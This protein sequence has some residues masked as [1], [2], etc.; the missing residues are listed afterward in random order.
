MMKGIF[1]K[2]CP[3]ILAISIATAFAGCAAKPQNLMADIEPAKVTEAEDVAAGNIA[4]TDFAVR[5]FAAS[6]EQGKNA[7]ISPLSVFS[8]LAMTAN[9]AREETLAQMEEVLGMSL[10]EMNVY[11]HTY[12]SRLAEG[13]NYKLSL[14]NSIWALDS[15][16][17]I[18]KK[19][20]LQTTADY[21][22][23]EIYQCKFDDG[24]L[25][26][27][28]RWVEEKTDGMIP[29]ILKQIP[30]GAVM[31]LVN[32]LAFDA[33]WAK[34]YQKS[35]VRDGIF[36]LEDGIKRNVE[37]MYSRESWYLEDDYA[38]GLIKY[39][40]DKAYAFVAL[41]PKEGVSVAQYIDTL[42][43]EHLNEL[44]TAPLPTQVQ[45]AIPKFESEYSLTMNDI[46]IEMGMQDAFDA[47]KAD[48]SGRYCR[49]SSCD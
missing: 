17:F 8:A 4:A 26:A 24:T 20:F 43:G 33:K 1:T 22:D 47:V 45:A 18:P 49:G 44:L 25:K 28:N 46:L 36:T 9:G 13:E 34:P 35:Q 5:L 29:E 11:L 14:A 31:F 15:D 2:I 37:M 23:A 42:N 3:L 38:M 10:E 19:D 21:Y 30:D 40:D 32:A 39:Y 41:L 7:L 12:M 48:F 16:H 6:Y 27:V